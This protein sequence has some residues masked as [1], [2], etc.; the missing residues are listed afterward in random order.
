MTETIF[1]DAWDERVDS[2]SRGL[3]GLTVA[4][5][6][7]HDHKFDPIPTRDYYSLAGI[8]NGSDLKTQLLAGPAEADRYKQAQKRMS[9]VYCLD[10]PHGRFVH[11]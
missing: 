6:R 11:I 10:E 9:Q 1:T 4:C 8:Y 7:C 3:L 5:A 2:V